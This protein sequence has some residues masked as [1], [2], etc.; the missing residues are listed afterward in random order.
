MPRGGP[1]GGD[2]GNG[3]AVALVADDGL[4]TLD[5]FQHRERFEAGNGG[6]GG[7]S[8]RHGPAGEV[9]DIAVPVGTSVE[10]VRE[11]TGSGEGQHLGDLTRDGER[12]VLA[13]G[14]RGGRG[15]VRFVSATNQE[16][17]LAEAGEE[18]D[19]HIVTL[20]LKLLADVGLIGMPNAGKSSL[21]AAMTAARPR[22]ADYPFTTTEP[23]LGVMELGH[24]RLI[25]VD[26]PGLIEGAHA[27][28]G[29]GDEFLRHIER[30]RVLAHVVDGAEEA[31]AERL[32]AVNEELTA[33]DP[34]LADRPQ[35][36]VINK[37]D[38]PGVSDRRSRIEEEIKKAPGGDRRVLFV[39][40]VARQGTREL[41]TGLFQLFDAAVAASRSGG[42]TDARTP[43]DVG[44]TVL[45]PRPTAP[46]KGARRIRD[47]FRVTHPRAIRIARG[48]DLDD[49]TVRVQYHSELAR[50][51]VIRD[52][53]ELG[54][55]PGDTVKVGDLEFE[56][57]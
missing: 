11:A 54:V 1:S 5:R 27:G 24:R 51:G 50:L 37:L 6:D 17:R 33:F 36:V 47:G 40:A 23:V 18:G 39:S 57:E 29:L 15:N 19:S 49:W 41:V 14:G 21:L 3:G 55:D 7:P 38:L 16:P 30:T 34:A 32:T 12:L 43:A 8:R 52:L 28:R 53:E 31:V 46:A 9:L 20:E 44:Q 35:L 48:S 10:I 13:V 45:R 42:S 26:I 56:W 22:I 25:A 2:G 4:N